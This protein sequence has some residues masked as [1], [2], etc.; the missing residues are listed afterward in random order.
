M[1]HHQAKD[2]I[3][4]TFQSTFDRVQYVGFIRNLLNKIDEEKA[5]KI[6]G[7][8]VAEV[9]RDFVNRY[10]RIGTYTDPD[11]KKVDL[12]IVFLQKETTLDRARTAQRNFIAR[13]LKDRGEKDAGLIAFVSPNSDDWRFSFVKMDYK[14]TETQKGGIKA[15]EEFTPAK[16]YSFLVG[17]HESSHTAQ[18]SLLPI[19]EDDEKNPRLED[20]EKAFNVEKVTKEFFEKYREL[21]FELKKTLDDLVESDPAIARDFK[22]KSI[23]TVD[24]SKKLLGQIV[25]LY[26]LQKKGWFGVKKGEEWGEGSKRFLRELFEKKHSHYDNFFND[27]LEPLF[28]EALRIER[29]GD[30]YSPFKCRIP[31]L[32]G[33]L[34]DPLNDYDWQ[35]T[36]IVLPNEL[37]SNQLKTPEGD[38]GTGIMDVFDRYNFTVNEDEPLEREVAVDPEMLG[39]VFENLLEIKDRKSK[40]TYYTPREIV[41][42]MCQ[43]SL[44]NYL[45]TELAGKVTKEDIDTLIRYGETVVEQEIRVEKAGKETSTY[46]KKL[47]ESIRKHAKAIDEK[48]AT[49][50]VCDPAVGSGAF[51]VGMMN[52]IV[53]TRTALNPFFH[54]GERSVY[55]FKRDAIQ[56]CLYGVDIDPGAVE[57]AKLRLWLSLIVDEEDIKKIKPLPNLDYKIVS[58]NS[59]LGVEKNLFNSYLFKQLEDL[60]PLFFNETNAKKKHEYKNQIDD[61][62]GQITNGHKDFDFEVYFSEV[63]HENKGFDVIIANPPYIRIQELQKSHP[64][65]AKSLKTAYYSASG[66]YD[67]YVCFVELAT[68][69]ISPQGNIAFILPHKFFQGAFGVNI[70]EIISKNRLLR[71]VIDFGHSQVFETATTYTCLLFLSHNNDSFKFA[72]FR[73]EATQDDLPEVFSAI[74]RC[75][76]HSDKVD[77]AVIPATAVSKEEWLFS[78]SKAGDV[79][80]KL[81]KQPR[82]LADVCAKIFQGIATSADKIYFLEHISENRK[83]VKAFSKALDREVEVERA[84]VKPMLK[85]ADIHRWRK[86]SHKIWCVFPYEIKNDNARLLSKEEFQSK[87]PL[88]WEYLSENKEE[89]KQRENFRFEKTWWQYSRPQNLIEFEKPKITTPE[90][91]LGCNMTFDNEGLYHNTKCYSFVFKEEIAESP[92]YLLAL[93]NSKLL[94]FFL[95]KTGYVLRGG[96]FVFKTNYLMPFPIPKEL[97]EKDQKP[98]VS[99]IDSI[100]A[101]TS[102]SDYSDNAA[103]QKEVQT[104]E[105][106]IDRMVYEL[107]GLNKDEIKIIEESK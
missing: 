3:R 58:G 47:P 41:H 65:L 57:I 105:S 71:Q 98:F 90:I 86:L 33:G 101:I 46:Y 81:K 27:V 96:Y 9:F 19:L 34:F 43:E 37:F 48:L 100:L 49:I 106:R 53:R 35:D 14:L 84:S 28:Y 15:I 55:S 88:A 56:N 4:D 10:E 2:I 23:S 29:P 18:R 73:P 50:R 93:L 26:F 74:D 54:E 7:Q 107:Y 17:S 104:L 42:Y 30:Y 61:L 68:K 64:A 25:F 36:D 66:S 13:Y 67:I 103:K 85:G 52:E 38:T 97:S 63:F 11:G 92:K 69:R 24:F 1:N 6:H 60:K 94:W 12:L 91:S 16:R 22:D 21:F 62:I 32:N 99:L 31:F 79:L 45:T 80:K 75:S 39:K 83:T 59:L 78:A 20:I 87:F 8:Y 102:S 51:P 76:H 95:T 70:R 5:F 77:I 89:L 44:S 82:T 72:E 40:G